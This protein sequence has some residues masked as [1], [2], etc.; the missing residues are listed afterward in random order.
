MRRLR[1]NDGLT[2][3][4]LPLGGETGARIARR[5]AVSVNPDIPIT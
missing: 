1:L 3:T 5:P 4:G 2:F